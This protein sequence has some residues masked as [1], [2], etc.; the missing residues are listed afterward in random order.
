MP[1][2]EDSI[3]LTHL[4]AEDRMQKTIGVLESEFAKV[5]TGR[6]TTGLVDGIRVDYY[7]A[8]TPLNQV[9]NVS[10]PDPQTILIQPWDDNMIVEIE[11]AISQSDL[12]ITPMNDGK[13]IRLTIPPLTE[14][15]RKEIVKYVAKIAEE[16]RVAIRQ[17]RKDTNNKIKDIEKNESLS[18]DEIK[19]SLSE[20]Q[21]LTDNFISNIKTIL[22]KKE[23]EILEI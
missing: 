10:V 23:K 21:T 11:K 1:D 15:R 6:A 22:E 14:E 4:D 18:E 2:E 13:V 5:R 17:I 9:S 8:P 19:K 12:G 20:I 3:E 7:G 16:H